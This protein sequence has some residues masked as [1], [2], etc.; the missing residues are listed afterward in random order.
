MPLGKAVQVGRLTAEP[1]K[2][3]ED[4]RC[5]ANARCVWAGRLVVET[6]LA[7]YGFPTE[8]VSL[9]LGEAQSVRGV[10]V[11]LSAAEPDAMAG[12][13]IA[14]EDYRFTFAATG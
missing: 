14:A 8:T 3:T 11:T 4:S 5:P 10:S 1:L 9:K 2:V 13:D 6:A 7:E 12:Q